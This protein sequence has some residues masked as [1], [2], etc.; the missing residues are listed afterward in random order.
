MRWENHAAHHERGVHAFN[1]CDLPIIDMLFGTFRNPR[2]FVSEAGF[3]EGASAR[4]GA[5]LIGRDV[6]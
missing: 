2:K 6:A 1:Y 4:I 5:M 3:R